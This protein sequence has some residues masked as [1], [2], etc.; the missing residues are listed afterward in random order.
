MY[1]FQILHLSDLHIGVKPNVLG[2]PHVRRPEGNPL[3]KVSPLAYGSW[4][5]EIYRC[6]LDEVV[7]PCREVLDAVLVTG[8]LATDG[9]AADL[10]W[11]E[12][13]IA[14]LVKKLAGPRLTREGL[15]Q[16]RD[17]VLIMPGNHDRYDGWFGRAGGTRFERVFTRFWPETPQPP[18]VQDRWRRFRELKRRVFSPGRRPRRTQTWLLECE[19]P[20]E[21]SSPDR[22]AIVAAD[23][24]LQRSR[25]ASKTPMAH[26]GQGKAYLHVIDQLKHATRAVSFETRAIVWAVHFPPEFEKND[27]LLAL[28][29]DGALIDA[30]VEL[31]VE[32]IFCGHT[33]EDRQYTIY[34]DVRH[35]DI[36]CAG[37]A[38]QCHVAPSGSNC[39]HPLEITVDGGSLVGVRWFTLK[40]HRDFK[41]FLSTREVA[42]PPEAAWPIEL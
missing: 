34:R 26:L 16:S 25:D 9:R 24:T 6:L 22:L 2:W 11:A 28:L 14:E 35:V 30:A 40:W 8:D 10:A 12:F 19:G 1:T 3:G 4:S 42:D 15:T 7:S 29:D 32:H 13:Q 33:H 41:A 27:P 20:S 5:P 18:V 39:A 38:A 21:G 36:H 17:R 31:D 37:T 23:F